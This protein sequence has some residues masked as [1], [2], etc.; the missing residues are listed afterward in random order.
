[1]NI[2]S[3]TP[4]GFLITPTATPTPT[5]PPEE[6]AQRQKL[7]KAAKTVND[8][9]TLGENQL[10]FV[11]DR[12]THRVI[13]RLQDRNT[14]EVVLQVPPEYVLRLAQSLGQGSSHIIPP[15]GS[16]RVDLQACKLEYSIVSPK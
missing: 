14:H 5:V 1:M 7:L 16:S 12:S 10:V 4:T 3:S 11:L 9:G 8:S 6:V 13:M 2:S 15:V